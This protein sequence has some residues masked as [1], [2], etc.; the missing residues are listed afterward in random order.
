MKGAPSPVRGCRGQGRCGW[1]QGDGGVGH[2][3][4]LF[5]PTRAAR[6]TTTT[7][8]SSMASGAGGPGCAM[9]WL[10]SG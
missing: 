3:E 6:P 1:A 10:W 5:P 4:G 7:Y 2:G 9:A 8:I